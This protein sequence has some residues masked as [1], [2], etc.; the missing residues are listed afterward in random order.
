MATGHGNVF[1]AIIPRELRLV[2]KHCKAL[3]KKSVENLKIY[4][5]INKI[6]IVMKKKW[7][8]IFCTQKFVHGIDSCVKI[9]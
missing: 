6:D 2:I 5:G 3:S 1:S 7:T 4:F 9:I 8:A